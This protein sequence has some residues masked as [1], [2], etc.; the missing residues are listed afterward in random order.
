[1][2]FLDRYFYSLFLQFSRASGKG[3]TDTDMWIAYC[4]FHLGDHKRAMEVNFFFLHFVGKKYTG[5]TEGVSVH[6]WRWLMK[7][8]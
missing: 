4:A 5:Y 7:I 1:M 6:V 8:A 3:N 2:M